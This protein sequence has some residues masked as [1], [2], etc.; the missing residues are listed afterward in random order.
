LNAACVAGRFA[1][2]ALYQPELGTFGFAPA[3]S[4]GALAVLLTY[5]STN[6]RN[7]PTVTSYLSKAKADTV[8]G[9]SGISLAKQVTPIGQPSLPAPVLHPRGPQSS[10]PRP[11]GNV[12]AV[13]LMVVQ[14]LSAPHARPPAHDGKSTHRRFV[15]GVHA[16]LS[17]WPVP[18]TVHPVQTVLV[19]GVQ[20][21]LAYWPLGQIVHP[22]QT[23]LVVAVHAALAYWPLGQT[24][25][26][27]QTVL[28]VAVHAVLAYCPLGQTEHAVQTVLVV[29]V[30]AVLAYCPLGQTVH[31][32]HTVSAIAV[33]PVTV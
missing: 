9:N 12:P 32:A 11:C 23:V 19:V 8:D 6:L 20:A 4:P 26:A 31:V 5:A 1:F 29:A 27:V 17:Y 15:V 3:P 18:Q 33:Q 25:H 16:W 10:V 14:Q 7:R 21:A 13:T 2:H 30:H 28:A 24:V 22:V